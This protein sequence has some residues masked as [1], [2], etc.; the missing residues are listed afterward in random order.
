VELL[1]LKGKFVSESK[2]V[3]EKIDCYECTLIE[4]ILFKSFTAIKN[5]HKA[6]YYSSLVVLI[7]LLLALPKV[8]QKIA[9]FAVDLLNIIP[10]DATQKES[11]EFT[12]LESHSIRFREIF[13]HIPT[14]YQTVLPF[15]KLDQTSQTHTETLV[16][17]S[18]VEESMLDC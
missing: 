6:V 9:F 17:G 12:K 10:S 4:H 16:I 11:L 13:E 3:L 5:R 1:R 18:Q 15:P 8:G 7:D 14:V 2:K